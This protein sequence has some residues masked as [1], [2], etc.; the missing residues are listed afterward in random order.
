MFWGVFKLSNSLIWAFWNS[1]VFSICIIFTR[2]QTPH[3]HLARAVSGEDFASV[4]VQEDDMED[5]ELA[6]ATMAHC[7]IDTMAQ[8]DKTDERHE[9]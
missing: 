1:F 6:A 7:H 8:A 3:L 9:S 5:D 4:R 2:L